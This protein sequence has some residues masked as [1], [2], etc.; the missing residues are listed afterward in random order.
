MFTPYLNKTMKRL[1]LLLLTA[2]S[3]SSCMSIRPATSTSSYSIDYS[4]F[5]DKGFFITE[6][7]SVSFNY[8]PLSSV[9][10]SQTSGYELLLVNG[11]VQKTSSYNGP[12][13]P[14]TTKTYIDASPEAVLSA[15]YENAIKQGAN[16]II[17]LN[18]TSITS[19]SGRP[20]ITATGMAIKK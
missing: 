11:V 20:T 10:S 1:T 16:G 18:I 13:V 2:I 4:K 9:Y 15:L 12:A 19:V 5:A 8:T 6:S 14:K 7:N 3:F 17:N